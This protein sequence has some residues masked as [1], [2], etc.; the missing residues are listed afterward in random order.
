M[1]SHKCLIIE[2][3]SID[4]YSKDEYGIDD[5]EASALGEWL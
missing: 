2:K 5:V 1:T 3:E 4:E